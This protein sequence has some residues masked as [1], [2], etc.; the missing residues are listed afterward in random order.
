VYS[1]TSEYR[2][3]IEFSFDGYLTLEE[4]VAVFHAVKYSW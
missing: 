3:D 1:G 4:F 2:S